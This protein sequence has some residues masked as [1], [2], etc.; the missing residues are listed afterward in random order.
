MRSLWMNYSTSSVE[1]GFLVLPEK[2]KTNQETELYS[3]HQCQIDTDIIAE[4]EYK[5]F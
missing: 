5:D 1:S 4:L 2:E 3:D